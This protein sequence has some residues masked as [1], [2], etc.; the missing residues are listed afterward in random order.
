MA[1]LSLPGLRTPRGGRSPRGQPQDTAAGGGG[2]AARPS[3]RGPAAGGGDRRQQL[4]PWQPCAVLLDY[5]D[6][7]L[8]TEAL[9]ADC[10]EVPLLDKLTPE[11]R[12]ALNEVDLAVQAL[13][14]H[15]VALC[16]QWG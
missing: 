16:T 14:L 2:G 13:L 6:T 12:H 10:D 3:P 4:Q 5:D 1:G 9:L 15:A 7:L 8:P 11:F